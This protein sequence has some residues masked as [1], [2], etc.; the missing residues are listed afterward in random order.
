MLVSDYGDCLLLVFIFFL[1]E[2]VAWTTL[3]LEA[4]VKGSLSCVTDERKF[5][6]YLFG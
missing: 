1:N 6:G 3:T 5:L 2:T 4:G